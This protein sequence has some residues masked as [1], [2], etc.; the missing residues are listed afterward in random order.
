[1]VT[2]SYLFSTAKG[3]VCSEPTVWDG[4]LLR[5]LQGI[6]FDAGSEP[7]VWDGDSNR[8]SA[9]FIGRSMF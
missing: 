5:I 1:M 2:V 6:N 3:S 8:T 7:T 9:G 4:D